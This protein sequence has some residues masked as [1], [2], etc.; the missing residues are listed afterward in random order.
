MKTRPEATLVYPTEGFDVTATIGHV[1]FSAMGEHSAM[2][3]AMMLIGR[4]GQEARYS[5]PHE[6]GG[7]THVTVEIERLE[8]QN[9]N[10][11]HY[12]D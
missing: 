7:F 9:P 6:D 5:F 1:S 2:E 4:H 10:G 8:E 11:Q 3:A 12:D